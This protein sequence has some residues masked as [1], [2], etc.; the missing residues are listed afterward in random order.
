V[1]AINRGEAIVSRLH[2]LDYSLGEL[3]RVI[4]TLDDSVMDGP[5]NCAPW[6]VRRLASHALNNQLLWAG[7]VTGQQLVEP[8]DALDAVPIP[9]DLAPVAIDV[10]GRVLA[11]WRGEGVLDATHETPFGALPGSVVIDFAIIDAA[12]H[13]W[14]LSASVGRPVE[15][16]RS[17]IPVLTEVVDA[18]CTDAA[19]EHDVIK[20]VTRAPL[21]AT[22][23][24]RLM[25]SA[26]RT[27][28]R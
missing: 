12:A 9:G 19:R 25:A 20:A 26:G 11:M 8:A 17:E 13:A 15:F 16:D 6:S 7:R 27:I 23:T 10:T 24:E 1:P 18:T 14:D 28:P 2:A 21:D 4:G 5:T 3:R 22:D